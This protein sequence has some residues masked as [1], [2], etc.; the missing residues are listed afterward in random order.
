MG[1][2]QK[3]QSNGTAAAGHDVDGLERA[4]PGDVDLEIV[5]VERDEVESGE[6]EA[7]EVGDGGAGPR[8]DD[9]PVRRP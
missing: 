6:G 9:V 4:V 3:L 5:L 8:R 7:V 1:V 2:A